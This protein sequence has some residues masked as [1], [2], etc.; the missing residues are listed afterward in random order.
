MPTRPPAHPYLVV[1]GDIEF[2]TPAAAVADLIGLDTGL[3]A[4]A[5]KQY[6]K[7]GFSPKNGY[8]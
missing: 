1:T 7:L 5:R 6:H 8:R 3:I 4:I 2:S